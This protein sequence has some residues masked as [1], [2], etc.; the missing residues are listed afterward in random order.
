MM[1]QRLKKITD[2]EVLNGLAS[3]ACSQDIAIKRNNSRAASDG[4]DITQLAGLVAMRVYSF[5][6]KKCLVESNSQEFDK[7]PTSLQKG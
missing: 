3:Y 4:K 5:Q 7:N 1:F 6:I 2:Q